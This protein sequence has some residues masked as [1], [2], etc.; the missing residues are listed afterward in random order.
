MN[1]GLT[2][3]SVSGIYVARVV[4]DDKE[5]PATAFADQ[6]R[7]VLEAHV[8]NKDLD[9]YGKKIT[10]ELLKKIRDTEMFQNDKAL[11]AAIA[12]D[13]DAARRYFDS[14]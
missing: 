7:N 6:K 3:G 2:G 12:R 14:T 13:V 10:I 4:Y 11:K 8:L 1:I 9:L 5:Y